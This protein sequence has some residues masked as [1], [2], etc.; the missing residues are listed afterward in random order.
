MRYLLPLLCFMLTAPLA[1]QDAT[2]TAQ[3]EWLA[4]WE[5]SRNYTLE[6]LDLVPDSS[7]TF[8]PTAGQ[9]SIQEQAQHIAGNVFGLSRRYLGFEPADFD[10]NAL[11][12][13]LSAETMERAELVQLL[14]EAYDFGVAAI[15]SLPEDKWDEPVPNFFAG[16]K[17][18]RVIVYLLQDH[19]THHRAQ[20]LVYLRLLNI[21]PPRY[22]GW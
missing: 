18:R 6:A 5:N 12:A 14:N 2:P 17:S 4:K 19:A 10:E 13:Q 7:L 3:S 11:R 15:K 16:P 1:A 8:R 21:Q 22:R 9:M 20:L